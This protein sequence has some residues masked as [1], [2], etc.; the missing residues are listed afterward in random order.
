[1][2]FS[3]ALQDQGSIDLSFRTLSNTIDSIHWLLKYGSDDPHLTKMKMR[4][5]ENEIFSLL[6]TVDRDLEAEINWKA[7]N[8]HVVGN[9]S[10]LMS[11]LKKLGL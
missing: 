2:R 11:L 9:V 8:L 7:E 3:I 5:A 1:M 10:S 4:K 6:D